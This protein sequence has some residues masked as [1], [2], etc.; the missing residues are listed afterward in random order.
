MDLYQTGEAV[1]VTLDR[2]VRLRLSTQDQSQATSGVVCVVV[3]ARVCVCVCGCVR[4]CV[5]GV[6]A[7][8]AGT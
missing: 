7:Y 1:A 4:T 6:H 3:C 8:A 5:C 2:E